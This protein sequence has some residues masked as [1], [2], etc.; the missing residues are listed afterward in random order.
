M[1]ILHIVNGRI[2]RDPSHTPV[3]GVAF[4]AIKLAEKQLSMGH[5]VNLVSVSNESF[6]TQ[7]KNMTLYSLQEWPRAKW[8]LGNKTVDLR[9]HAPLILL[10]HKHNFDIIHGHQ[11][12]YFRLLKANRFYAHF[13]SDPYHSGG[14]ALESLDYK[15]DDWI[16][17]ARYSSG[18]F[19]ASK[20]LRSQI[21]RGGLEA[22]K[23]RVVP[24]GIDIE[25]F[26]QNLNVSEIRNFRRDWN[27]NYND[28]VFLFVGAISREKGVMELVQCFKYVL[29]KQKNAKLLI[30]GASSLWGTKT[31]SMSDYE[32]LVRK[33]TLCQ[34]P[35]RSITWAGKILN[36]FMPIVYASVDAVVAPS[37]VGEGFH[38]VTLEAMA[39]GKPVIGSELGGI[40]E[41]LYPSNGLLISPFRPRTL[42]NAMTILAGN[43]YSGKA[44]GHHAQKSAQAYTWQRAADIVEH[45][46][47]KD[48]K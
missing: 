28:Y 26:Q 7:W 34:I 21:I 27:F 12:T 38:L 22:R 2:P 25:K 5:N 48:M 23:I 42:V 6:I 36:N 14:S 19:A 13:H 41:M 4:A 16:S 46:Y 1:N 30:V 15:K 3:S 45:V 32:A 33:F 43:I 29:K 8:S 40:G 37:L 31:S 11:Y 24:N 18:Y 47:T 10:T 39:S 20:Y 44:L 9:I 17:V 35:R